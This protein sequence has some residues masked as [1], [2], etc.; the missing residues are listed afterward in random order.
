MNIQITVSPDVYRGASAY[1][2]AHNTS[3]KEMLISYLEKLRPSHKQADEAEMRLQ[4]LIGLTKVFHVDA[5]DLNGDKAK[6][7]YLEG[8]VAISDC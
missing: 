8:K 1:A 7:K 5:D 6:S 2:A 4:E 3:V